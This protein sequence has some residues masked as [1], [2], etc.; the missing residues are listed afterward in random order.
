MI[1]KNTYDFVKETILHKVKKDGRFTVPFIAEETGL[2]TTTIAKQLGAL[3]HEIP[4]DEL[5]LEDTGHKGRKAVIY[6]IRPDSHYF[7]GV[8]IKNR[9]LSIGMMDFTGNIVK[10]QIDATYSFENSHENLN[11]VCTKIAHFLDE[12]TME[13][14]CRVS[15]IGFNIGGR[16]DSMRGTS[17]SIYNFEEMQDTPLSELL[18]ETLGIPAVIENDTKAMAYAEYVAYGMESPDVLYVNIGWGLGLGIIIGGRLYFGV[19]GYSGEMGHMRTYDNNILC[20]CGKKG[21][22]ET[23]VS[24]MAISRKVTERILKGEASILSRKVRSGERIEAKD[25]LDAAEKEDQLCIEL[26]SETGKEL[27]KQLAG[28]INLFN[29]G[30]IIIGGQL[31]KA[32]PFYFQQQVALSVKQH[33]L[34]LINRN[35]PI[36]SSRLGDD[37]GITGACLIAR[38]RIFL[39]E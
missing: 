36:L 27:G 26:I 29:P 3:R 23:E 37:A 11:L 4:I 39:R 13:E 31:A 19:N 1:Y 28:I 8:D 30:C 38:D 33:S 7:M 9:G 5:E 22:L 16:V 15:G 17:A 12:L 35:L 6:G 34:K 20:H 14:R 18:S 2:S 32:S 24:L 10:K 21:C 25:I